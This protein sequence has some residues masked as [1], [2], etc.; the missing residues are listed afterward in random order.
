MLDLELVVRV[1]LASLGDVVAAESVVEV[2]VEEA[3]RLLDGH[4]AC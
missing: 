2:G 1:E 4:A 3:R